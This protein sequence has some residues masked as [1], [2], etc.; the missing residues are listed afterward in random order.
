MSLLLAFPSQLLVI[1]ASLCCTRS[2]SQ[3]LFFFSP[4]FAQPGVSTL[5]ATLVLAAGWC[6]WHLGSSKLSAGLCPSCLGGSSQAGV[7]PGSALLGV[8]PEDLQ[9]ILTCWSKGR[10]RLQVRGCPGGPALG[11]AAMALGFTLLLFY[12]VGF[13][14]LLR[15]FVFICELSF[16]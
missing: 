5:P 10:L 1:L 9:N 11:W 12:E 7:G 2:V 16:T 3:S 14:L 4:H 6:P 15:F 13:H 8:D